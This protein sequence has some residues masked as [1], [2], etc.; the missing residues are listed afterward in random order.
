MKSD[1][2]MLSETWLEPEQEEQDYQLENYSAN[3][4]SEGRG[5]G[6]ASYFNKKFQHIKNIKNVGYTLSK[7][8]SEKLD[9]FGIYKSKEG[10]ARQ[11]VAQL[12]EMITEK[13]TT[14][15]GGD[16]N[17]CALK[18]QKNYITLKLKELK[19]HQIV[20]QATHIEGGLIDHLYI[21]QGEETDLIWDVEVL[22][23]YFTDHDCIRVTVGEKN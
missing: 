1:V 10:D 18:N 20:K 12:R 14:I 16:F 23:K 21:K 5:R 8:S 3:F 22:P 17:V 19:F 13:K 7:V 4:N 11:M 6:I 15:I 9:V 2:I